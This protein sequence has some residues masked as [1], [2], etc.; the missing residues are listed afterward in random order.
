[1]YGRPTKFSTDE[2][3][4]QTKD[5]PIVEKFAAFL[6]NTFFSSFLLVSSY[7]SFA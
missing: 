3:F 1:M 2:V 5:L 4:Q 6:S 7:S